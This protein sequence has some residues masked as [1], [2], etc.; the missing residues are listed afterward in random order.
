[1]GHGIR[2]DYERDY[3]RDYDQRK[4][5]N[6][7]EVAPADSRV[8]SRQSPAIADTRVEKFHPVK[9]ILFG[10]YARGRAQDDSDVDLLVVADCPET[11]CRTRAAEIRIS[12][13]GWRHPFDIIVRTP[14]QFEEEKDIQ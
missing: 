7:N 14:R 8:R 11:E 6:Q 2:N 10:S 9:L 5:G 12:L 4:K 1:M 13:W 3:E